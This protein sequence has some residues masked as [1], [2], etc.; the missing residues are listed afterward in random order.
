VALEGRQR[1][2]ARSIQ[3]PIFHNLGFQ[4]YERGNFALLTDW[5]EFENAHKA[6]M[7]RFGVLINPEPT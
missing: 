1:T 6:Y 3:T 5:V 2:E 7:R 4:P